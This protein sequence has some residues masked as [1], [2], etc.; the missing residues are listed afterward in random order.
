MDFCLTDYQ[1]INIL[2]FP[3][4]AQVI[5][6]LSGLQFLKTQKQELGKDINQK[7]KSRYQQ[8]LFCKQN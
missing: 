2:V 3:H 6:R 4:E 1:E 8:P 7:P 5:F